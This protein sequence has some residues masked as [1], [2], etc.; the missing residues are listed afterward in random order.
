MSQQNG[1][2]LFQLVLQVP[3]W[4]NSSVGCFL[5]VV[6]RAMTVSWTSPGRLLIPLAV[7]VGALFF[8]VA[9]G[10][11]LLSLLG[12]ARAQMRRWHR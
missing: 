4:I 6:A 1:E 2:S 12:R 11:G 5:L 10:W 8:F 7:L 9:G 3:W